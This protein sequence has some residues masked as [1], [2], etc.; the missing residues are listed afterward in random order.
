M[1]WLLMLIVLLLPHFAAAQ[2]QPTILVHYMPWYAAKPVSPGWGWHWTMNH[3]NPDQTENGKQQLASHFTPLIGPYD[4]SDI[5]VLQ[6]QLIQ[7]KVAGI[8]GVIVDWYGLT[9]L[10]DYSQLHHNTKMLIEQAEA[11]KMQFAICYED[12]TIKQLENKNRLQGDSLSHARK[13]I[14]WLQHN[15]MTKPGYVQFQNKPVLLSFG[16][17]NLND[18]DP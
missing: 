7:M 12:Q 11:L 4:S 8:D 10:F 17:G 13:E 9:D 6:C 14:E 2:E 3:F 18:Q 5:E 15:W 1:K 16:L